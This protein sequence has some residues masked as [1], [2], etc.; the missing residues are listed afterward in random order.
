M[1][2]CTENE[3]LTPVMESIRALVMD[4]PNRTA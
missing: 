3:P 4:K 2:A 1:V